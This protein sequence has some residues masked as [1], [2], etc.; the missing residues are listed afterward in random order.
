[1]TICSIV[2]NVCNG[3]ELDKYTHRLFLDIMW[4]G[5]GMRSVKEQIKDGVKVVQKVIEAQG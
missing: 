3:S 1:M 5:C 2:L 4:L